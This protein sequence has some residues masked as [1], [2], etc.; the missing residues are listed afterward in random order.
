MCATGRY[1]YDHARGMHANKAVIVA[2]DVLADDV[3]NRR[4][5]Y[6]KSMC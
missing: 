4:S 6:C 3:I 5:T 2:A 1:N